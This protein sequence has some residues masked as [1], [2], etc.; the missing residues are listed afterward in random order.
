MRDS[1]RAPAYA[2]LTFLGPLIEWLGEQSSSA[3]GFAEGL[4]DLDRLAVAGHSRGGKLATLHFAGM[5]LNPLQ[6][7]C[8]FARLTVTAVGPVS[9]MTRCSPPYPL[10]STTPASSHIHE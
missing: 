2:Q 10:W 7:P 4:L 6:N 3:G 9:G 1:P 8:A 5:C